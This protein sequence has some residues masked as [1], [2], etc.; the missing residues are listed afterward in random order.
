MRTPQELHMSSLV[1][2]LLAALAVAVPAAASTSAP[3]AKP[4]PRKVVIVRSSIAPLPA[5]VKAA[6][7][8]SPYANGDCSICHARNDRKNPG[9][10]TT[11]GNELCFGCHEEFSGLMSAKHTHKPAVQACLTCHN[12]HDSMQRKLLNAD[13][14]DQCTSCHV[15]IKETVA[16]ATTKHGALTQ[17]KKCLSCHNPHA[18][19][20]EKL[21]TA[22]PYDQCVACHSQEGLKD[23]N[24]VLLTNFKKLLD[25]NKVQHS[26]V[27]SKDCSACHEVHG[28]TNF[29][30]LVADYPAKFYAP[31]APE[32]YALCF[33]CHNDK[34]A[35]EPQTTTLTNFRDGTR[36]LH[37]VHVNKADRGRTCRAC[38]EVHASPNAH[39]LRES[40]PY[41]PKGWALKVGYEP[42]ATG[43][44][45]ARTCHDAKTYVNR[46]ASGAKAK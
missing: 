24:G 15:G 2:S 19:N 7:Q 31:Y 17:G 3:A 21:L 8:H 20:V 22:L 1:G 30:L 10:V 11:Q 37:Y 35:A 39:Q 38:H 28:S 6:W 9:P 27:E 16:H 26:P 41:G 40:V 14:F 13:I 43:G 44:T 33:G 45:C 36:N 25:A 32:N 4:D 18:S 29:R 5:S 34:V 23:D 12:P 42:T 46:T